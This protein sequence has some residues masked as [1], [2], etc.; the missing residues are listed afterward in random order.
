M[1]M[2]PVLKC[3]ILNLST[4]RIE[5]SCFWRLKKPPISSS[6]PWTTDGLLLNGPQFVLFPNPAFRAGKHVRL[7]APRRRDELIG[8]H[9]VQ[10][11]AG[12]APVEIVID[13]PLQVDLPKRVGCAWKID[14]SGD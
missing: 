11:R 10:A 13:R 14:R 12:V 5:K 2:M 4:S 1:C 9:Q 7:T 3:A 6:T 8:Q